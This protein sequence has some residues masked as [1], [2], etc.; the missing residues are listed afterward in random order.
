[1]NIYYKLQLQRICIY[2]IF[3]LI[4]GFY[5]CKNG[6]DKKVGKNQNNYEIIKIDLDEIKP[7]KFTEIY[8]SIRYIK[9][10]TTE[11]NSLGIINKVYLNE[12]KIYLFCPNPVNIVSVF[13]DKGKFLYTINKRGKGPG[14]YRALYDMHVNNYIELLDYV[15]RKIL[16]FNLNGTL[17]NE[18]EFRFY[19]NRYEKW[20]N[21]TLIFYTDNTISE[22]NN[23]V[24]NHNLVF[25]TIPGQRIIS[26]FIPIKDNFTHIRTFSV[27]NFTK[28]NNSILFFQPFNDTVY[29][30][31]NPHNVKPRYLID[32]GKH[33]VPQA[34]LEKKYNNVKDL[35][36]TIYKSDYV[37]DL[38]NFREFEK[39]IFFS[40]IHKGKRFNA[41]YSKVSKEVRLAHKFI[42]DLDNSD[43]VITLPLQRQPIGKFDK[44][45][46]Y[47]L[48]PYEFISRLK[49]IKESKSSNDWLKFKDENSQLIKLY[50]L[51]K[52]MDN[53]ILVFYEIKDF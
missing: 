46:I 25:L 51:I 37:F 35:V 1:M 14:E 28:H 41:Y 20:N 6:H 53:P 42:N 7:L 39:V 44:N 36:L 48:E 12:G 30:I 27:N 32:F 33:K 38:G 21:D 19:S 16:I 24:I 40:F 52:P 45:L 29:Q 50:E 49:E 22:L 10:E 4:S 15:N 3:I 17:I 18:Y 34:L 2:A 9:L 43:M 23:E 8:N 26:K 5:G 47:A 13:S 11:V 31:Y